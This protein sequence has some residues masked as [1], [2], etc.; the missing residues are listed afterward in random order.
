MIRETMLSSHTARDQEEEKK[1]KEKTRQVLC[2]VRISSNEN[3]MHIKKL[4]VRN[5]CIIY[6]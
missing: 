5:W 1:K 2:L 6:I 3:Q 4:L